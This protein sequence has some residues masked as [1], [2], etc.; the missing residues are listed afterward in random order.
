MLVC[1]H[2]NTRESITNIG[3][4]LLNTCEFVTSTGDLHSNTGLNT[5]MISNIIN[6]WSSSFEFEVPG[7]GIDQ[8]D[9]GMCIWCEF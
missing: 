1:S 6:E 4:L 3:S 7:Y 8:S 9:D 5:E 2:Y